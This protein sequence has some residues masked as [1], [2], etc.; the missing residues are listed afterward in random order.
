MTAVAELA[1][2]CGAVQGRVTDAVAGRTNRMVCYCD[3]CQAYLHQLRRTD[4]LDA[5]GGTDVVQVA[6]ACLSFQLGKEQIAGMRLSPRGLYRWYARCC[7]TPLGNTLSPSVPF[8]GIMVQAFADA[9]PFGPPRGAA[10]QK[11]AIGTP[12]H[13]SLFANIRMVVAALSKVSGWRLSGKTWPHPFFDRS[14]EPSHPITVLSRAD[15]DALR[16]LCGPGPA[17]ASRA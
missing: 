13:T 14:G 9:E 2:R 10:Q 6:P 7:N 8:V 5:H 17:A 16:P 12:P 1:C 4:L 11:F 3:D 15:R